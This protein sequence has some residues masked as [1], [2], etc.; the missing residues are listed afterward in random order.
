MYYKSIVVVSQI[1]FFAINYAKI[2]N[3]FT[4][5]VYLYLKK[6]PKTDDTKTFTIKAA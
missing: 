2:F 3:L 1:G 4:I 5:C 6:T